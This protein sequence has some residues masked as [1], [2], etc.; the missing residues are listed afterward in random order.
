[1]WVLK[2]AGLSFKTHCGILIEGLWHNQEA[3]ALIVL[4]RDAPR[5]PREDTINTEATRGTLVASRKCGSSNELG[6]DR[7]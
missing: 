6:A 7:I 1:M 2:Y 3:V 5:S 4:L